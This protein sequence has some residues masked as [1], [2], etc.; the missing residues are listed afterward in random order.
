MKAL[1]FEVSREGYRLFI[2][3]HEAGQRRNKAVLLLSEAHH[4]SAG[5]YRP[6]MVAE[7]LYSSNLFGMISKRIPKGAQDF[8]INNP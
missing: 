8:R 1:P 4:L 7:P 2:S 6:E 5:L 3:L